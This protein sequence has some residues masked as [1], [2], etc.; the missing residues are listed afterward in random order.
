LILVRIFGLIIW[1]VL[2]YIW[3]FSLN[4]LMFWLKISFGKYGFIKNG[5]FALIVVFWGDYHGKRHI[6]RFGS[7]FSKHF[8]KSQAYG[9]KR[10]IRQKTVIIAAAIADSKAFVV[11]AKQGDD[12]YVQYFG[13]NRA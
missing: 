1:I 7:K 3:I 2:I 4:I 12:G 6:K 8:V 11:E 10:K 5:L 9:S 13:V